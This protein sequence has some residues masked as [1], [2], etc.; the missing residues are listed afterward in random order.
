MSAAHVVFSATAVRPASPL[1]VYPRLY[2]MLSL[3]DKQHESIGRQ[4]ETAPDRFDLSLI[5]APLQPTIK[6]C[7][8]LRPTKAGASG[9]VGNSSAQT[10]LA[11]CNA[12]N[13]FVCWSATAMHFH[14]TN[15]LAVPRV[16]WG[17]VGLLEGT[18]QSAES[19]RRHQFIIHISRCSSGFTAPGLARGAMLLVC[20]AT[21][22]Q[23][24]F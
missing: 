24:Y 9:P 10:L 22:L 19:L 1:G 20:S 4:A 3:A 23:T 2:Q 16:W 21:F 13:R 17:P 12:C 7:C 6:I 8:F 18:C 5:R 14:A 15:C 11:G